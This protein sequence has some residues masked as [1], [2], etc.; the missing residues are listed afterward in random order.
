MVVALLSLAVTGCMEPRVYPVCVF[1]AE[2]QELAKNFWTAAEPG[3]KSVVSSVVNED[4]RFAL[5]SGALVVTAAPGL[6]VRLEKIWPS[7]ACITQTRNL[8]VDDQNRRACQA[9]VI[10]FLEKRWASWP[11]P[12]SLQ[13]TR[14]SQVN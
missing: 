14:C 2:T 10:K 4:T 11:G 1:D 8:A 9:D 5:T 13:G 12:V 3:L 6:H 7:F